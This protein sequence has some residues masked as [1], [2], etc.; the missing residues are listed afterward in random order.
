VRL[1]RVVPDTPVSKRRCLRVRAIRS[2]GR[3]VSAKLVRCVLAPGSV[4]EALF[5]GNAR[6]C[7]AA[8]AERGFRL[9]VCSV[10]LVGVMTADARG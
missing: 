9:D 6:P 2:S 5:G 8:L 10:V 1:F 7:V 4:E 3:C